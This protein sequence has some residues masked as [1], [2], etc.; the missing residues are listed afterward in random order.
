M[1]GKPQEKLKAS[2]SM[3]STIPRKSQD[4]HVSLGQNLGHGLS[5]HPPVTFF[6][7]DALNSVRSPLNSNGPSPILRDS[8]G[9]FTGIGNCCLYLFF[10]RGHFGIEFLPHFCLL[11]LPFVPSPL[12]TSLIAQLM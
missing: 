2:I 5:Y 6:L 9:L 12:K 11:G 4:F 3:H 7:G 8:F 1:R 10:Y